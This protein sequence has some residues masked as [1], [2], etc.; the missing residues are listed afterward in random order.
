MAEDISFKEMSSYAGQVFQTLGFKDKDTHPCS[1]W[2][3]CTA[4]F[5]AGNTSI[6]KTTISPDCKELMI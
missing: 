2:N 4:G 5:T 3:G 1:T 6:N